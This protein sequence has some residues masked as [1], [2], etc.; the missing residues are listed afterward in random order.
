M[1]KGRNY[2]QTCQNLFKYWFTLL[3]FALGDPIHL[4][5]FVCQD[6]NLKFSA[7][8]W[9]IILWNLTKFH[10]IRTTFIPHIKKLPECLSEWAEIFQGFT[11]SQIKQMLKISALYLNKQKRF[12]PKKYEVYHVVPWI[13]LSSANRCRIVSKLS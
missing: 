8:L 10:L 13:V 7:F 9:F 1:L 5:F 4:I 6:R 12:I 11:K 3:Y 2:F